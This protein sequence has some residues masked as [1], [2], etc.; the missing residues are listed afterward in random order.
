MKTQASRDY[1]VQW[2]YTEALRLD[3]K[4]VERTYGKYTSG[5]ARGDR[6]FVVATHENELHLLG[7]LE[8]QQSGKDGAEVLSLSGTF[9]IIPLKG[10]KWRLRFEG[11]SSTRLTRNSPIAMQVQAR[12]RLSSDSAKLLGDKLL[13]ALERTKTKVNLQEGKTKLVTLSKRERDR[14]LR[15][16][17]LAE[18]GTVCEICGFDFAE[19]YGDFAKNCVEVHH[20]EAL[21][22]AGREGITTTLE[23][24]LVVCPNCHS[25]LH[26]YKNPRNWKAFRKACGLGSAE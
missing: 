7:A 4:A 25:A 13:I 15:V 19:T 18:R 11:T 14:N 21:A 23:D 3:G 24:V 1:L 22:G 10:V 16:I 9:R 8:V 17:A 2:K 6:I 20:I 26:Q 5:L 12:R